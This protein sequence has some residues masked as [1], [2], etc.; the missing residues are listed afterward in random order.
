MNEA[1]VSLMGNTPTGDYWQVCCDVNDPMEVIGVVRVNYQS[2]ARN[3]KRLAGL[4]LS[5]RTD[6]TIA[7][8]CSPEGIGG[9]C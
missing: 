6:R 8:V 2:A 1:A 4:S 9:D 5:S 3:M 7:V